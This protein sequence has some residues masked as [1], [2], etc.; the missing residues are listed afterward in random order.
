M[1]ACQP[2]YNA[3]VN[4]RIVSIGDGVFAFTLFVIGVTIVIAAL[5]TALVVTLNPTDVWTIG[6]LWWTLPLSYSAWSINLLFVD[7]GDESKEIAAKATVIYNNLNKG[8][9]EIARP[10]VDKIY[11][12][13]DA[14]VNSPKTREALAQRLEILENLRSA[15][16][17]MI[18]RG[19]SFDNSDI[20]LVKE[21]LALDRANKAPVV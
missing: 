17:K 21:Y 3:S 8:H 7:Q 1:N 15:E 16:N 13:T 20:G 14:K 5:V 19:V 11:A 2:R 4:T 10:V 6:Y 9:K 18:E 12:L